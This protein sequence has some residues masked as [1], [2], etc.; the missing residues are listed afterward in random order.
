MPSHSICNLA[1]RQKSHQT[2]ILT[3][4]SLMSLM[5]LM[6]PMTEGADDTGGLGGMD[7]AAL[8]NWLLPNGQEI[9]YLL[10]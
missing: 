3:A 7:A 4:M 9:R 5:S 1:N 2:A 8:R 10:K 6:R